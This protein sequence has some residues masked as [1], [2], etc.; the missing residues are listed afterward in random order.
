MAEAE[1]DD[2]FASQPSSSSLDENYQDR[3]RATREVVNPFKRFA[4]QR[5]EQQR[6][7]ARRLEKAKRE[8][9]EREKERREMKKEK[10]KQEQER[11]QARKARET[12]KEAEAA[13]SRKEP[14]PAP[15]PSNDKKPG[16]AS[17][18]RACSEGLGA[19]AELSAVREL[20]CELEKSKADEP[21]RKRKQRFKKLQLEWHPDKNRSDEATAVFQF[22]QSKK[23]WYLGK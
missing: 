16:S 14:E 11:T 22:L 19:S 9:E 3:M 4:K 6:A 7:Q 5:E 13:R 12:A 15:A 23:S 20:R 21:H 8:R 18:E 2:R 10:E 17:A 1:A